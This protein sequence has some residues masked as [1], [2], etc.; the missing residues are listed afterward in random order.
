[1]MYL[2]IFG[3]QHRQISKITKKLNEITLWRIF[4][5][6]TSLFTWALILNLY[7]HEVL[8]I[9][10]KNKFVTEFKSGLTFTYWK[11]VF[12]PQSEHILFCFTLALSFQKGHSRPWAPWGQT[13]CMIWF[14]S[15]LGLNLNLYYVILG[16][17]HTEHMEFPGPATE[18]KKQLQPTP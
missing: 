4:F 10:E 9:K 11:V 7:S 1:M 18:S 13:F 12:I 15:I 16:G 5:I 17:P 14:T 6:S 8:R 3:M 2:L